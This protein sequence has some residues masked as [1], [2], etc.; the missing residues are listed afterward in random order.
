MRYKLDIIYEDDDV[1]AVNKPP[2]FLSIPDRFHE[3]V[4][5]VKNILASRHGEIFTVH[6]LDKFTSGVMIF[7]KNQETHR[8]LSKEWMDRKP[9][10]YYLAIVDGIP[11]SKEGTIDFAL[12]ESMTRR[13]KMLVHKRGKDSR[14]DYKVI[15]EF[16]TKFSLVS[17]QIYTGRMH[18]IRVHMAELGHPLIVDHLYGKREEFFLSEIKG[19]K[20]NLRKEEIERPLLTRQPLHAKRLVVTHPKKD[21][22]LILEAEIP[23]D[24]RAVLNQMRKISN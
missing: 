14:S 12:S 3:D 7:A 2:G 17:V 22:L 13:G 6:R 5:N 15:E 21:E 8:F 11:K 4:L 19:R 9:Q 18:Q 23:K 20:F 24:M 1:V 10:K 16:G